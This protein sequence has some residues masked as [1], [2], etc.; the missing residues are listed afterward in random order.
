MTARKTTSSKTTADKPNQTEEQLRQRQ[1]PAKAGAPDVE[2]DERSPDGSKG[3]RHVKE[4]VVRADTWTG[5]DYQHEAN[6]A[7]LVGEAIQ[8]GLHPRGDVSFDGQEEHPDGKSL[9]L[10]YSV[11][12]VPSSIDDK[13]EDT[14]TP[15][16]VI[17]ADGQDTSSSKAEG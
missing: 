8:R 4:F 10:T 13:A 12:T 15:R 6:R 3:T 5:E 7:A 2:V 1:F 11:E 14:T 17:E 9:V 16:D